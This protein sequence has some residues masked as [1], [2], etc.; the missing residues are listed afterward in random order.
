M[1]NR[2]DTVLFDL[3]GTLINT[4]E[5]ILRSFEHTFQT[6]YPGRFTREDC[7]PFIGP[8]LPDTFRSLDPDRVDEM[9]RVYRNY[10]QK[11]H[12]GLVELFDGVYETVKTLHEHGIKMAV[13]TTKPKDPSIRGLKYTGI[14]H[15]FREVIAFED[16]EKTKP[17]PEPV[18]KALSLL[19]SRPEQAILVGDSKHDILAAKNARVQSCG[20]KW[21]IQGSGYLR[22]FHPDFI[23]DH[24]QELLSILNIAA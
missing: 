5:L 11:H 22:Q 20:V 3:D 18:R 19:D 17:D 14:L 8:P 7:I 13:V 12:D 4:Y 24:M 1:E 9:L 23:I 6:Y 10:Y 15:F 21:T 2:I 16:V